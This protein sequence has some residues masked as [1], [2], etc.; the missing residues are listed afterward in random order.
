[1]SYPAIPLQPQQQEN[2]FLALTYSK[3]TDF[4]HRIYGIIE[5]LVVISKIYFIKFTAA[6]KTAFSLCIYLHKQNAADT[7]K[8]DLPIQNTVAC[9]KQT[10]KMVICDHHTLLSIYNVITITCPLQCTGFF[11]VGLIKHYVMSFANCWYICFNR[12]TTNVCF[13]FVM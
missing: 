5:I 7:I 3:L 10:N 6:Q 1:M 8:P 9:R 4:L 13:A 2:T 11:F 12:G